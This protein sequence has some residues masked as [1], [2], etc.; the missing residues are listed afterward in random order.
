MPAR[1]E[2]DPWSLANDHTRSHR[3]NKDP[4]RPCQAKDKG[5]YLG[6]GGDLEIGEESPGGPRDSP[7]GHALAM[8]TSAV[9]PVAGQRRWP[10]RGLVDSYLHARRVG[11]N[12][13]A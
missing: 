6:T 13:W 10:T 4:S 5:Q 12:R 1:P 11:G 3:A 9:A 8:R 2:L 7:R